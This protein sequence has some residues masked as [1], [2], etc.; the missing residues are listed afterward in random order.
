MAEQLDAAIRELYQR[1]ATDEDLRARLRADVRATLREE[2]GL[3]VPPEIEIE[4]VEE[5]A[6][7]V[8]LVLPHLAESGE[9]GDAEL[10]R[11]AGGIWSLSSFQTRL[12]GGSATISIPY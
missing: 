3:D 7:K 2:V 8:V 4:V 9:L 1:A 10:E 12:G 11:A 6:D 5:T